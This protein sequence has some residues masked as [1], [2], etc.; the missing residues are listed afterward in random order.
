MSRA[1]LGDI[2]VEMGTID[3]MQLSSAL[4]HQRQWGTPLGQALVQNRF[5]DEAALLAGLARQTGMATLQLDPNAFDSSYAPLMPHK[6]AEQHRAIALRTEG[7]RN[8]VLV[9]AIAAPGSLRS[10][11]EIQ[12]VTGKTRIRAFLASDSAIEKA[13]GRIYGGYDKADAVPA[14][15]QKREAVP[16]QEPEFDFAV[17]PARPTQGTPVL[18]YGFTADSGNTLAL[19]L[20][21][22]GISARVAGAVEVLRAGPDQVVVGAV[23]AL[24]TLYPMGDQCGAQLVVLGKNSQTDLPRAERLGAKAFFAAPLNSALLVNTVR[25]WNSLVDPLASGNPLVA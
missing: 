25:R 10:L 6:V 17:A 15:A 4:A 18:I 11:D 1:R 5:C 2:L 22:E 7:K 13:L 3:E 16:L 23:R 24:E 21:A 14:T 8:E 12:K 20:A 19:I 9:V